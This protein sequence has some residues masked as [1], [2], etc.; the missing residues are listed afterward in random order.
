M[1]SYLNQSDLSNGQSILS[2]ENFFNDLS[3]SKEEKE[4]ILSL[5]IYTNQSYNILC[6]KCKKIP[7]L[8][9]Q[10]LAKI[11]ASCECSEYKELSLKEFN[12]KYIIDKDNIQEIESNL[13]CNIQ[14]IESNFKCFEHKKNYKY[15]CL[16]DK[17]NLCEYCQK[18]HDCPNESIYN[19]ENE[20]FN[21]VSDKISYI[22][23]SLMNANNN[24]LNDSL[25]NLDA[26][27]LKIIIST[28]ICDYY[29]NPNYNTIDNIKNFYMKLKN[30]NHS[31]KAKFEIQNIIEIK[32]DTEYSKLNYYQKQFI[33]KIEINNYNSN[34]F[35]NKLKNERLTNLIELNLSGNYIKNIEPLLTVNL[36][37]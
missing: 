9:F 36:I 32:K 35:L 8:Q 17:K 31:E 28:L 7:F 30:V 2:I 19:F 18:I 23:K 25:D 5:L 11:I 12:E 15:Y 37:I 1:E 13:K 26:E 10:D 34:F 20:K 29:C 16:I 22:A 21:L 27:R 6:I 14:E 24:N 4:D 3:L 33:K